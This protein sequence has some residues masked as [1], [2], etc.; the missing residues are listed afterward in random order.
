MFRQRLQELPFGS[1]FRIPAAASQGVSIVQVRENSIG[2][3]PNHLQEL[4]QRLASNLPNRKVSAQIRSSVA[5]PRKKA[6]PNL[7]NPANHPVN[8][9]EAGVQIPLF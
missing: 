4:L 2:A 9:G 5:Q 8:K 7:Q 1:F 6:K 3:W